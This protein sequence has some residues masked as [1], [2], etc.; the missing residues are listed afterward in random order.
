MSLQSTRLLSMRAETPEAPECRPFWV[1][2]SQL[3]LNTRIA[4]AD[5]ESFSQNAIRIGPLVIA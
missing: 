1:F 2:D 4:G 5:P 3:R